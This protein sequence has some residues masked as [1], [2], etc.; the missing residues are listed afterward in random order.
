HFA[1]REVLGEI[2]V[3]VE[4]RPA[5]AQA[6]GEVDAL[7]ARSIAQALLARGETPSGVARELRR[8]LGIARNEAY[9]IAQEAADAG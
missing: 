4:G 1:G 8:R 7:A 9:R 6:E 5:D 3:V 2:V